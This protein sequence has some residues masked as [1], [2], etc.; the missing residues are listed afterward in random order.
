MPRDVRL[1]RARLIGVY[2]ITLLCDVTPDD[3]ATASARVLAR[4]RINRRRHENEGVAGHVY[5]LMGVLVALD[6]DAHEAETLQDRLLE[7]EEPLGIRVLAE[8]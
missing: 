2:G 7:E 5:V 1:V 6:E 8:L 3:A 4:P